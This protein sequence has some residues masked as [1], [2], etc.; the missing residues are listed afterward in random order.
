LAE[1]VD[2]FDRSAYIGVTGLMLT[3][4]ALVAVGVSG[5]TQHMIGVNKAEVIIAINKDKNA[6][7]FKQC[8]LGFVGDLKTA[9]P[10]LTGA[11]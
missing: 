6:P 7:V 11:L 10:T 4:R 1:A 2:W 8:D 9:L 5:Q 3:P